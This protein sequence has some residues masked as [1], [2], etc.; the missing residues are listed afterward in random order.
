MNRMMMSLPLSLVLLVGVGCSKKAV[1][2]RESENHEHE[3]GEAA[4][5]SLIPLKDIRGLRLMKVT[6]AKDVGR[7][8]P[9]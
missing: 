7:W 8:G 9:R 2:K 5:G 1:E 6:E 3:V 4:E